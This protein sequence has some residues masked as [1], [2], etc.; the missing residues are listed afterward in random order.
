MLLRVVAAA[1]AIGTVLSGQV[2]FNSR[3]A[4]N[5]GTQN[6]PYSDQLYAGGGTPPYTFQLAPNSAL[7]PGIGLNTTTGL[8]SGTP[9]DSGLYSFS[10]TVTDA[11]SV[12]ATTAFS[13]QLCPN[14]YQFTGASSSPIALADGTVGQLYSPVTAP[15]FS[16]TGTCGA[17][18]LELP[19]LTLVSG[20]LPAG[21]RLPYTGLPGGLYG[22]P[23]IAG[24]YNFTLKALEWTPN[25]RT[26]TQ[27][28]TVTIHPVVPLKITTTS[29]TGTLN[30]DLQQYLTATGGYVPYIWS[31]KD[32]LR[33]NLALTAGGSL[34]G[35]PI[36][37]GVHMFEATVTDGRGISATQ[38]IE[39]DITD[40]EGLT[41][42]TNP[43][44]PAAVPGVPY[45]KQL[46]IAGNGGQAVGWSLQQGT[47]LPSGLI[48]DPH[49]G[50]ISGMVN[51]TVAPGAYQ[52]TVI[53][54]S[55]G[56][57][58]SQPQTINVFATALTIA[59]D[60]I[61]IAY[62]GWDEIP[63]FLTSSSGLISG[64]VV[65]L[66]SGT[67][68]PGVT[69][70][71]FQEGLGFSLID[72]T[73]DVFTQPT[74][75]AVIRIKTPQGQVATAPATLSVV[76]PSPMSPEDV[77]GGI[78]PNLI[79]GADYSVYGFYN[80]IPAG[81][82]YFPNTFTVTA[83]SL[84]P[85]MAVESDDENE[86]VNTPDAVLYGTPTAT[87]TYTFTL[88]AT[89]PLGGTASGQ[90][91]VTVLPYLNTALQLGPSSLS[92][93][94]GGASYSLQLAPTSGSGPYTY[95]VTSGNLPPGIGL[96]GGTGLLSGTPTTPGTYTFSITV[97]DNTDGEDGG[98]LQA[99]SSY[100]L[101]I[102]APA[103]PLTLTTTSLPSG[104]AGT[105]Y[106][107]A[108]IAATGGSGTYTFSAA[109]L[110][111]GLTIASNG[112]ITG[113][114][115]ETGTF[116]PNFT[117]SDTASDTTSSNIPLTIAS[118][119]PIVFTSPQILPNGQ[120]GQLYSYLL[121]WT[122]GVAPYFVSAS[123]LPGWL[124][125]AS[126]GLLAGTPTSAGSF[127][128]SVTI[129]DSQTPNQN[130]TSQSFTIVVSP[131][132]ITTTTPLP[133]ATTGVL[134]SDTLVATGGTAGYTWTAQGLPAWLALSPAG[135]LNGTPPTAGPVTFGVT[136]TDA[137]QNSVSQ[138]FTLPVNTTLAISTGSPLP[139][140]TLGG[141]ISYTFQATGGTGTYTWTS[142]CLPDW[143]SLDSS[144]TLSVD[145]ENISA[146]TFTFVITVTDSAGNSASKLFTLTVDESLTI[147]TPLTLPGET[148]GAAYSFA[149][150]G[151]GGSGQYNWSASG[152][153][154]GFVFSPQGILTG[155][156]AT[157]GTISLTVTLT[158]IFTQA[159][160]QQTF[161]LP[162]NT[163]LTI[164]TTS[165]LPGSVGQ[166]YTA[167]FNASGG[168][169]PYTWSAT[170]L[171]S[172]L[173]LT[174]TGFLTGTPPDGTTSASFTVTAADA[175][176]NTA[177]LIVTV[178]VGPAL[179]TVVPIIPNDG[180]PFELSSANAGIAYS[181]LFCLPGSSGLNTWS[182]SPALPTW[183]SLPPGPSSTDTLSGTPP[184]PGPITFSITTDGTTE[185]FTLPVYGSI[186][187]TN[188]PTPATVNVPY[189]FTFAA[190]GGNGS[191][192]WTASGLPSWLTLSSGG[193][194]TGTPLTTGPVTFNVTVTDTASDLGTAAVT[195]QVNSALQITTVSPLPAGTVGIAESLQF[196]AS[197][198]TGIYSWSL[199][200]QPNWLTIS[201]T[202]LLT[203]VPPSP[204]SVSFNVTVTD[205]A[206]NSASM[207][208]ALPVNPTLIL[209]PLAITTT[210]P[211]PAATVAAAYS[212]QF[213]ASG[214]AGIYTWAASQQ[215]T[216]LSLSSTGLL[217]GTPPSS[218]SV[219]ITVT[220]MDSGGNTSTLTFTLPVV[221]GP[222]LTPTPLPTATVG[223][224]YSVQLGVSG[225]AGVY[226][227]TASGQPSW[228][229]LST[230]GLLTGTPPS[231]GTVSF[232]ITL[233]DSANNHG[234]STVSL[235][236]NPSLVQTPL[237]ITT[238][239]PLPSALVGIA[240]ALQFAASGGTAPYVWTLSQQPAWLTL[241]P[242][243]LLTGTP[244]APGTVSFTV[245]VS[246]TASHTASATFA[247]PVNPSS[248]QLPLNITTASLPTATVG[249]PYSTTLA[250]SGGVGDY[251]WS[252]QGVPLGLTLSTSGAL[253]G[254]PTSAGTYP[255]SVTVTSDDETFTKR[256]TI[257]VLSAPAALEFTTAVL[258]ACTVGSFCSD[259]I[260]V[261]GGVPN[262]TFTLNQ[263]QG[264]GDN[265][266][267]SPEGVVSGTPS[268]AETLSFSVKVT[269]SANNSVSR[270]LSI[271]VSGPALT[272][273]STSLPAGTVGA[274]YSATLQVAGGGPTYAWTLA[275]GSLPPGLSLNAASG[276]IT[277]TPT[278]AGSSTFTVEVGS[279][280]L[281]SLPST[282]TITINSLEPLTITSALQ[283]PQ[284]EISV[285]YSQS[286][287]A[288]GGTGA[289][290]W[291]VTGGSLPSGLTL[292]AGGAISGTPSAIQT[293]SFTA[294]VTD[295]SGKTASATFS[296]AVIDPTVPN[297]ITTSP[298]PDAVVDQPYNYSLGVSGGTP[299]Y[300]W[301]IA[302]GTIPDGLTFSSASGTFSGIPTTAGAFTFQLT[303]TDS[304]SATAS[305]GLVPRA[306]ETKAYTIHVVAPAAF[307]ITSSNPLPDATL[308]T[309]YM[310]TLTASNGSAP[311]QWEL[312]NGAWP[313]GISM[314][315]AGSI[316]GAPGTAGTYSVIVQAIDTTGLVATAAFSL[317]VDN[318]KVPSITITP[319]PANGTVGASYSQSLSAT[320]GTTPY[321]WSV[322]S[323]TL[324][325]GLTLNSNTGVISGTPTQ[326]G[327]F[328]FTVQITD[329][330][331]SQTT[332]QFTVD[333]FANDLAITTI[334]PLPSA[335]VN[336]P[337][338]YGLNVTG[339]NT[340]YTWSLSAGSLISGF[341]IDPATGVLSGTPTQTGMLHFNISVTDPNFDQT[342]QSFDLSVVSTTLTITTTQTTLTATV[343]STYTF[344]LMAA[345]GNAPY[346][347]SVV[348]GMLPPGI[349][350]N[351]QSGALTGTPTTPGTYMFTVQVTDIT[352][353]TAQVQ[354][355]LVVKPISFAITT[356]SGLPSGTAG[357]S[358]STTFQTVGGIGAIA[359]T[360]G[361]GTPSGLSLASSTG[362][363]SGIP[364]TTGDFN[365]SVSAADSKGATTSQTYQLHIAAPTLMATAGGLPASVN[366][367]DQPA[368]NITLASASTLPIVLKAVL[369]LTP[370]V[371][372]TTDLLFANGLQTMEFTIP[373]NTTQYSFTFMAGTV[374]GTIQVGLTFMEAGVDVT[375]S[376]APALT[377]Q[378]L[379]AAPVIKSMVVTQISGGIQLLIDGLST[380]RD[381]KT[382]TFQFT[383]AS[384][385]TLQTTSFTVDVSSM[386]TS[387]YGNSSSL[388]IG[389]QFSLTMPFTIGGNVNTIASV[390]ATL[391]NSVGTSTAASAT[392]P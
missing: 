319:G 238:T 44:L 10:L 360:A 121:T 87:G 184:A 104:T 133:A 249:I 47:S 195:L 38:Q 233:T 177:G 260:G 255:I 68:P 131:L 209:T 370:S 125:L 146:G 21:L 19:V 73:P 26:T 7:P 340:P 40:T 339:G 224:L 5:Y 165:L 57:T 69:T 54:K 234:S 248:A 378:I 286:L 185:S 85:G 39:V 199:T 151:A 32:T 8:L 62:T 128:F 99:T 123:G 334:S 227:F 377:T 372:A 275:S 46:G 16:F 102:A 204:G 82:T 364:A 290:S 356:A 101:T 348:K 288:I 143:L 284:A 382:A 76:A 325:P 242:T 294:T 129:K 162:V 326:K 205:S 45:S 342:S 262:Y 67:L 274:S 98:P 282:F 251:F 58:A 361:S 164:G 250:A 30:S 189:T 190:N 380:T 12:S 86:V 298:L 64:S 365:F 366:P 310:D 212:L 332:R 35:Q 25:G 201:S 3:S 246:D 357:T 385:A 80:I 345:Q 74:Y 103:I 92:P 191:Y 42:T 285:G 94:M 167:G 354:V 193:Q 109:G 362:V 267:L 226:T 65:D 271:M 335:S 200:M 308:N 49:K 379:A 392:I 158:D 157:P 4:F 150:T 96:N 254:T 304:G 112:N 132:S 182:V 265:L 330:A 55:G 6:V 172:W 303:V 279:G 278:S 56:Q 389:S 318:P 70:A 309:P 232:T 159:Q 211:L 173:V 312:A 273:T 317:T 244:P 203:G 141:G 358:Y 305:A 33:P 20:T 14:P 243:G 170:S 63:Y 43:I 136:V 321:G 324:P 241:S 163:A 214:G 347:W 34:E 314:D 301:A 60:P 206:G 83:G 253:S 9:T 215:P 363:L 291:A 283:L 116:S 155:S 114:P 236:V 142:T 91:T 52:Y 313:P 316:T 106:S 81:D 225:G 174:T 359:W 280:T 122:G 295:S 18:T 202:G 100:T 180:P 218:G 230:A 107:G 374:A 391:T 108:T 119:A 270:V 183:L 110:P 161:S 353:G 281:S 368:V 287:S 210:S 386:F 36:F 134:F 300:T 207:G 24:T 176:N 198:G 355:T 208:F 127:T 228:L 219:G 90:Y 77:P 171:P 383:P 187:I 349:T 28:F 97:T 140:A 220:V 168:S 272:I 381:M 186:A 263:T 341:S 390:S 289:Y 37:S 113:T 350:L 257:T 293:A 388:A 124:T 111:M 252:A 231:P 237:S 59:P 144:G 344:P 311:Y 276:A 117:V 2:R 343:G 247:L 328:P 27:N 307:H 188:A 147:V 292:A 337:Y 245:T 302:Q 315:S 331:G 213:A 23:T 53:A 336:V 71:N 259:S 118:S 192:S 160:T 333:I 139:P 50:I 51:A 88:T 376:P 149:F 221:T 13:I 387:W 338:S 367:S 75:S 373:P 41:I 17:V 240:Y 130:S 306:S 371:G 126:S 269:D 137:A 346:T 29:I 266:L 166:L 329:A 352:T 153:P 217:T 196:A 115:T 148:T 322:V 258:P 135:V 15:A 61:G 369:Q 11:T 235:L 268:Q 229:T 197:G 261:S 156:S 222:I 320:G 223:V 178:P 31:T 78:L 175:A 72:G 22:T 105:V 327:G 296:L 138:Q 297:I 89:D 216:W 48:L 384:G 145:N 93:G 179:P 79:L 152:L 277:G 264:I 256:L 66:L 1:L 194:L 120:S 181:V 323:G 169:G 239:S 154:A 375:P 95:A 351:T 299:P 84:P